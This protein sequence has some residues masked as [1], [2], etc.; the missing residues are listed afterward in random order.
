MAENF[1][2]QDTPP[3]G[4]A[5]NSKAVTFQSDAYGSLGT[6]D[7]HSAAVAG[8]PEGRMPLLS[9]AALTPPEIRDGPAE[10]GRPVRRVLLV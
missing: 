1:I 3:V 8:T 2:T 5:T 10:D 7:A 4:P 9:P 6:A